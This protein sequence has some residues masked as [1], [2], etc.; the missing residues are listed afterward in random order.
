M[1]RT[2]WEVM[3]ETK[4]QRRIGRVYSL[5][6]GLVTKEG[7]TNRNKTQRK[8]KSIFKTNTKKKEEKGESHIIITDYICFVLYLLLGA[9][10]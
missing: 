3:S 6:E 4:E 8:T 2:E 5:R 10:S 7:L 1:R 9:W